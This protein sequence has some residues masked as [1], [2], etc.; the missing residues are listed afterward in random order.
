MEGAGWGGFQRSEHRAAVDKCQENQVVQG[1]GRGTVSRRGTQPLRVVGPQVPSLRTL[2][3][4]SSCLL[5]PRLILPSSLA[6]APSSCSEPPQDIHRGNSFPPKSILSD[7]TY[8]MSTS[9]P[10]AYNCISSLHSLHLI[11]LSDSTFYFSGARSTFS[12]AVMIFDS[13]CCTFVF[14]C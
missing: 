5:C 1:T 13:F 10:L 7:P 6:G 2:A 12:S 8:T 11:P 9:Q 4:T 14:M 3:I